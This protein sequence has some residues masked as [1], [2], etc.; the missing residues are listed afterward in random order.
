MALNAH[1]EPNPGPHQV[2]AVVIFIALALVPSGN[3]E[4]Y[5][6]SQPVPMESAESI[7]ARYAD[8]AE[9]LNT[10]TLGLTLVL[11]LTRYSDVQ[12]EE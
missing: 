1:R 7:R 8:V 5:V 3:N 2:G 4:I 6:G 10:P 11:T 12:E 9:G